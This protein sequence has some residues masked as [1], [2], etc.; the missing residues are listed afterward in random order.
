MEH[1]TSVY[2]KLAPWKVRPEKPSEDANGQIP[3]LSAC[4]YFAVDA[5][6][7]T[8]G[9]IMRKQKEF[10]L[11]AH[12]RWR[13][14]NDS[15]SLWGSGL[16]GP[17][18]NIA[19][20]EFRS[21]QGGTYP[22]V[23]I[24][25]EWNLKAILE[26]DVW[27]LLTDGEIHDEEVSELATLAQRNGVLNV[28]V[29]FLITSHRE[30]EPASANISVGISLF[31]SARDALILFK[32]TVTGRFWIISAKG[33][34][35]KLQDETAED[36]LSSWD[37]LTKYNNEEQFFQHCEEQ[38]IRVHA[39]SSRPTLPRGLSLGVE[40]ERIHGGP[41]YV[42]L[43]VLFRSGRLP[44]DEIVHLLAEEAL[45]R[46]LVVCKTNNRLGELRA[47]I[48]AQ[49][50]EQVAPR[51]EDV[52]G[53]AELLRKLGD[54]SIS[55]SERKHLQKRLREAHANN[56]EH[57][58]NTVAHFSDSDQAQ[59]IRNRNQLADGALRSLAEIESASY[60]ADIL[61]RKSNR[62]RRAAEVGGAE[63]PFVS[64]DVLSLDEEAFRGF[65]LVCCGE[66]EVMSIVLLN[67]TS[68][69]TE[70]NTTDFALNNPLAVGVQDFNL[71]L[72]SSQNICFQCAEH[73][74]VDFKT[75]HNEP[76]NA[77]IPTVAYKDGNKAYIQE[78]LYTGLTNSLRTGAAGVSQ[79]FMAILDRTLQTKVWAGSGL[80]ASESEFQDQEILQR[81]KTF[82]WMLQQ[83]LT[84]T[85]TR[86]TFSE[87]GEW[88][89]FPVALEWV[90]RDYNEN[91]LASFIV[92]YPTDGFFELI[93]L[94]RRA[95]VFADAVV[96][97]MHMS[98]IIYSITSMYLA[99]IYNNAREDSAWKQRYLDLVYEEFN[100]ETV[101]Q[102]LGGAKSIAKS[103]AKFWDALGVGIGKEL[104]TKLDDGA[105]EQLVPKLQVLLFWLIYHQKAYVTAQ[106]FF[107]QA[108]INSKIADAVLD[109]TFPV[110]L[111][112]VERILLSIFVSS[113]AFLEPDLYAL[114]QGPADFTTPFGPSV[115]HCGYKKCKATFV[116]PN[117]GR[118]IELIRQERRK[119]LIRVFGI[120]GRFERND[121]GL[122]EVTNTPKSPSSGHVNLHITLARA[123]AALDRSTRKQVAKEQGKAYEEFVETVAK[124]ISET[125]R[126]NIYDPELKTYVRQVLPSF[127]EALK[128]A[129]K[130]EK[131]RWN[132]ISTF[133]HDFTKNT[134]ADKVKFELDLQDMLS[135]EVI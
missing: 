86:E 111:P 13:N 29:I 64:I 81:K 56:R 37:K 109:P 108:R 40:W 135:F 105:K 88:V 17:Q 125:K 2:Q 27:F 115:L 57:Y 21:N 41:V 8:A 15:A 55:G 93:S 42:D 68:G 102:D 110:P 18:T 133:E 4:K 71:R 20:M 51:L 24:K 80:Q 10:V 49:K 134:F 79:L 113:D 66:E 122:P 82:E 31:A 77:I 26:S 61:S 16:S 72:L 58:H 123:W 25:R 119:H 95:R 39:A 127:F 73:G 34:F 124:D 38:D 30:H 1:V 116:P 44:D 117:F 54:K 90:V 3:L 22:T 101:P 65:C 94:G 11:A 33:R 63:H 46:L 104:V 83:F 75:I 100:A 45:S 47:F 128:M 132:D 92:T 112:E 50:V 48:K 103:S 89:D 85:K 7:S 129:L 120:K 114:H 97:R 60:S 78:Q 53:A 121:T 14:P 69:K 52:A 9:A 59:G 67:P 87:T 84:N 19:G 32:E 23:L 28:P 62:A 107:K 12:R 35:H 6:G 76:M 118:N 91:G 130:L 74:S 5:S 96:R 126:G 106:S 99:D 43:D 98:K 36:D 70:E 131:G